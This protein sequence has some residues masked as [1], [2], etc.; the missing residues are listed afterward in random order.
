MP[1]NQLSERRVQQIE[2]DF[3]HNKVAL[4]IAVL[5]TVTEVRELSYFTVY[6]LPTL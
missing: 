3:N 4:I 6:P 5:A 2:K 1:H